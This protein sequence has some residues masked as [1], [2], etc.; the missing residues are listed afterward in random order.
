MSRITRLVVPTDFSPAS[1]IAFDYALEL[2]VREGASIHLLHVVDDASYAAAYPDG[3][4]VELPGL[5]ERL[6]A[7]AI[8]RLDE[9]VRTGEAAKVTITPHVLIGRPAPSITQ[10]AG[11]CGADLIVMGTHGRSGFAHLMLGSVAERVLRTAQC[12]VLT[13]RDTSR[14]ADIIAADAVTRRQTAAT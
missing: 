4:F 6:I 14:A 5:R 13:V 2:A 12:P 7:E 9:A 11:N 8:A 3:M 1:N 10:E